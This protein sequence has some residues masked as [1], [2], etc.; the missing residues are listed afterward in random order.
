MVRWE[1][2]WHP[3]ERVVAMD[4]PELGEEGS[5]LERGADAVGFVEDRRPEGVESRLLR[6]PHATAHVA[7]PR[8]HADVGPGTVGALV[9]RVVVRAAADPWEPGVDVRLV[10]R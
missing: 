3:F 6:P 9:R 5:I 1:P 10:W 8:H 4:R 7:L 2:G